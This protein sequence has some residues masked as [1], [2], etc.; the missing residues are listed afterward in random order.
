MTQSDIP[1]NVVSTHPSGPRLSLLKKLGKIRTAWEEL[2]PNVKFAELSAAEFREA[3]S[4]SLETRATLEVSKASISALVSERLARQAALRAML[5]RVASAVLTDPG[6]G[7]NSSLYRAMGFVPSSER[8]PRTKM[9]SPGGARPR[10]PI[11][12]PI[13][14]FRRMVAAWQESGLDPETGKVA[15]LC[16]NDWKPA[17][18]A[19]L[20][21]RNG[22]RRE[23]AGRSAAVGLKKAADK[24]TRA[25]IKKVVA[26]V[27]SAPD[28]GENSPLYRAM[29]Y[30]PANE[31]ASRYRRVAPLSE[32]ISFEVQPEQE[33]QLSAGSQKHGPA[34]ET[35]WQGE[36]LCELNPQQPPGG[37]ESCSCNN[38]Q[39][40][41]RIVK[42]SQIDPGPRGQRASE[43]N[44]QGP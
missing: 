42:T 5:K 11:V 12:S 17:G 15:G 6:H 41:R 39:H 25:L 2:A 9:P 34:P 44:T 38:L 1:T 37:L 35:V 3:T 7:D 20:E 8:K 4:A 32:P 33:V 27:I 30:I 31:R 26:G 43:P 16:L 19:L 13:N 28:L 40:Q 14:R 24:A 29:G 10:K 22:L 36:A 21:T 18:D 23:K